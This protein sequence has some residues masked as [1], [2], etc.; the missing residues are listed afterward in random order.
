MITKLSVVCINQV[1][2]SSKCFITIAWDGGSIFHLDR[3]GH[4]SRGKSSSSNS[5]HFWVA[6]LGLKPR[7]SSCRSR[8]LTHHICG[9][10]SYRLLRTDGSSHHNILQSSHV[11]YLP[12]FYHATSFWKASAWFPHLAPLEQAGGSHYLS[13]GLSGGAG[14]GQQQRSR[15]RSTCERQVGGLG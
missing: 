3:G 7:P 12:G 10:S 14:T 5:Y 2:H 1:L 9:L 11:I 6:E 8:A 13:R 4:W 15:K